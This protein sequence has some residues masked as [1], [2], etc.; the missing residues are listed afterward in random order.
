M[1]KI[2]I[3]KVF[4]I[5]NIFLFGIVFGELKYEDI[6]KEHWAYKSIENLVKKGIIE[7]N[8]YKFNG[9]DPIS[10]Y[11]FA[12]NL[13]KA[14]DRLDSGKMNKKD[15]KVMESLISEF[16]Q[17]LNKIGFDTNAFNNKI[18]NINETIELLKKRVDE[19]EIKINKLIERID[20]L[21]RRR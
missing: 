5:S 8:S 19:N 13:S 14:V 6:N 4:L 1:F 20:R 18:N 21:E 2:K 3:V 16:S 17:E 7:D 12:V 15:L 10:R 9:N 11:D